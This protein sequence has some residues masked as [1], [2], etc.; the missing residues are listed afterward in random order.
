[1]T[2]LPSCFVLRGAGDDFTMET[3]KD[4]E[5][6]LAARLTGIGGSEAPALWS[7]EIAKAGRKTYDSPV[8]IYQKKIAARPDDEA[9]EK[10]WLRV[11]QLIEPVIAELYEEETGDKTLNLGPTTVL[12]SVAHPWMMCSLDRV[13]NRQAASGPGVLECKNRGVRDSRAW[14]DAAPLEVQIQI[15]HQLAVTGWTWGVAAALIG[16]NTPRFVEVARDDRFIAVHVERCR[17]L[18]ECVTSR[19]LPEVDGHEATRDALSLLFSDVTGETAA[20][21]DPLRSWADVMEQAEEDI[22]RLEAVKEEAGNRLRAA[23][24]ENAVGRFADGTRYSWKTV[25]AAGYSVGPREYR[26]LRKMRKESEK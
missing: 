22:K 17:L 4:R 26:Q 9:D 20:L 12:R 15:Q 24:G 16:G 2:D 21:P 13:I 18:W 25:K 5:D 11:G 19:T 7:R 8:S 10:K 3:R 6:W 14:D 1:M 23:I